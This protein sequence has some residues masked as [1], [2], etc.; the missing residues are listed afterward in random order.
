MEHAL[1]KFGSLKIDKGGDAMMRSDAIYYQTTYS[2][3]NI[4]F[5]YY[6]LS[7]GPITVS[8]PSSI[9]TLPNFITTWFMIH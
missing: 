2:K 7:T 4:Y 6:K 8:P 3:L 1:I 5:R 9:L